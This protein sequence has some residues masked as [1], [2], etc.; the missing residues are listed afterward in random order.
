[1][2]KNI[3]LFLSLVTIVSC[4]SKKI[5]FK[6]NAVQKANIC[7]WL[8][9]TDK[10]IF[11]NSNDLISYKVNAENDSIELLDF[12]K[13]YNKIL[14]NRSDTI[15]M[16]KIA[17]D[18]YFFKD[19]TKTIIFTDS[20]NSDVFSDLL[21]QL[22]KDKKANMISKDNSNTL[23]VKSKR[24]FFCYKCELIY[25][26][27]NLKESIAERQVWRRPTRRCCGF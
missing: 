2:V 20:I 27:K 7:L 19:T 15:F 5:V 14:L 17:G 22:L 16:W 21:C 9:E 6:K 24:R 4:N 25:D 18:Y 11:L 23:V 13:K 3:I 10:Y 26:P 1:M 12:Q 8:I